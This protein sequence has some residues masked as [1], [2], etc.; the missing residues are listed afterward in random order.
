MLMKRINGQRKKK[1]GNDGGGMGLAVAMQ[2]QLGFCMFSG[3]YIQV[4]RP[5]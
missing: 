1:D 2:A 4:V 5:R 3:T